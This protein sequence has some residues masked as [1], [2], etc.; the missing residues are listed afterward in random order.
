MCL[1]ACGRCFVLVIVYRVTVNQAFEQRDSRLRSRRVPGHP[2]SW[3]SERIVEQLHPAP[4]KQGMRIRS[5][6]GKPMAPMASGDLVGGLYGVSFDR[7]FCGESM[8]SRADNASK[9]A[10]CLASRAHAQGR[11]QAARLPVHDRSPQVI[12]RGRDAAKG[13]S[14]TGG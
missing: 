3:I 5:N 7:V 1:R 2:E 12:G 9:V 8:F 11:F 6:A 10:L 4:P 13:V 14:E